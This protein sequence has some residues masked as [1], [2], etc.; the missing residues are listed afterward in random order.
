MSPKSC[1][2]ALTGMASAA[3]LSSASSA[4]RAWWT[5]STTPVALAPSS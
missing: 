4:T 3:S 5:R 1:R 2:A